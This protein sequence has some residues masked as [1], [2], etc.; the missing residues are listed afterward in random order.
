M[1]EAVKTCQG[2]EETTDLVERGAGRND[3]RKGAIERYPT[4]E[5]GRSLDPA[6]TDVAC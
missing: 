5:G 1:G 6:L 4:Q 3:D 2:G